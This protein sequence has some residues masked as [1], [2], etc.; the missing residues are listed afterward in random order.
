MSVELDSL[1]RKLEGAKNHFELSKPLDIEVMAGVLKEEGFITFESIFSPEQLVA[2]ANNFGRLILHR[3]S[4]EFGVTTITPREVDG[5]LTS[6]LGF[7]NQELMLHT[8][9]TAVV[10]PADYLALYCSKPAIDG[11][12]SILLDSRKLLGVL[13]Q[14]YPE[15]LQQ[16]FTPN[17]AIFG[18]PKGEHHIGS[19]FS[20]NTDGNITIRFRTDQ[21]GFYTAPL[22]TQMVNLIKIMEDLSFKFDLK[23]GQGY[24]VNNHRVLHARTSFI[25]TR[26]MHRVLIDSLQE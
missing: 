20:K 10:K 21:G 11:G 14:E 7:T 17:S 16:L 8:D 25:G 19:I 5:N 4:D 6:D 13:A 26:V 18:D 9:G 23:E 15:L 1:R 12:A 3:D 2:F 24:L 22:A